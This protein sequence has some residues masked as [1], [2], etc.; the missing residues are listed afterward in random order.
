MQTSLITP[1]SVFQHHLDAFGNNDIEETMKDYTD[2]S[3]LWT[4]EGPIV[5]LQAISSYF[6]WAFTLFPKDNTTFELIKLIA[7]HNKVY[8]VW[9]AESPVVNVSM[10]T[11]SFEM[12]DGK[13]VWHSTAGQLVN[14]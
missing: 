5:G 11:D 8:V 6:S 14:K 2:Q 9:R 12:S 7:K 13:I 10:A 4:P 3:E 1:E